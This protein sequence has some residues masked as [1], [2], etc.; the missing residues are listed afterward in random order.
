MTAKRHPFRARVSLLCVACFLTPAAL[1]APASTCRVWEKVEITL[2]AEASFANPYTDVEVW[3]DLKGPGFAKR[4]FGFWDGGHTF[5]IRVLA[6]QPG[7]WTWTSGSRPTVPGLSGREGTFSAAAWSTEETEANPCRRDMIRVSANGH[8]FA[9]P[10]GEPFFL[11]YFEKDCP[12]ATLSGAVPKKPYHA[13]WFNPRK[14]TWSTREQVLVPD[15][16]GTLKLPPFPDGVM[17]ST[18]DW[19]LRLKPIDP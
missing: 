18:T 9:T 16:Q 2:Q 3:V 12:R 10:D 19:A 15:A 11:L 5:R 17:R 6:T 13:R 7:V 8:A 1:S 4:C 14:G